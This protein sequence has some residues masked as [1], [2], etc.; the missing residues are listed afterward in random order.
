MH[1]L[2][3]FFFS[4]AVLLR[5]SLSTSFRRVAE[6]C[7]VYV[8]LPTRPPATSSLLWSVPAT[9]AITIIVIIS[10][11]TITVTHHIA[12]ASSSSVA[13]IVVVVLKQETTQRMYVA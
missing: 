6:S 3:G 12:T 8:L 7:T 13:S 10:I 2:A 11:I 5:T 9:P 1:P 4:L